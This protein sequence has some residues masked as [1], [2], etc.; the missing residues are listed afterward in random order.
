ALFVTHHFTAISEGT[1]QSL[2]KGRS[3]GQLM[4][5]WDLV[6]ERKREPFAQ[7]VLSSI[8]QQKIVFSTSELGA[9]KVLN[10]LNGTTWD[11]IDQKIVDDA[12]E[13]SPD[14]RYMLERAVPK[15]KIIRVST[16]DVRAAQNAAQAKS[17]T[18]PLTGTLPAESPPVRS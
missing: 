1:L 8:I 15:D 7:Q 9:N 3:Y 18:Q 11:Y 16:P 6:I 4:E 12:I 2:L 10:W 14:I 13:G 17:S 5:L